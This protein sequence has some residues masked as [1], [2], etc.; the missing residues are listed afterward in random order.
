MDGGWI[1][2]VVV[3]V[4]VVVST[5]AMHNILKAFNVHSFLLLVLLA[6]SLP[7]LLSSSSLYCVMVMVVVVVVVVVVRN[8]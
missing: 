1:R 5:V 2:G 3:V 7:S 4:V 8:G 6:F